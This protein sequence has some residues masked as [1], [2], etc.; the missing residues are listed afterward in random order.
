M[1]ISLDDAAKMLVEISSTNVVDIN[2]HDDHFVFVMIT[3]RL[4]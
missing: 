3:Y 1:I 2:N 4:I